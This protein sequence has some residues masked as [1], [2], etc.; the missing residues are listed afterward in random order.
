MHLWAQKIVNFHQLSIKPGS[1]QWAAVWTRASFGDQAVI[2]LLCYFAFLGGIFCVVWHSPLLY[3]LG[4]SVQGDAQWGQPH[5]C[6]IK[7]SFV[8]VWSFMFCIW[9]PNN[10][11]GTACKTQQNSILCVLTRKSNGSVFMELA[12]ARL[13]RS[14][15]FSFMWSRW[16]TLKNLFSWWERFIALKTDLR[17]FAIGELL[18]F[19]KQCR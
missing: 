1:Q 2:W 18:L 4:M 14:N 5:I 3:I 16:L 15:R 10:S 12:L 6:N 17:K 19:E 7:K 11:A 8:K 9:I 13:P